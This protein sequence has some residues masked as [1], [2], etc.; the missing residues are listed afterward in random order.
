MCESAIQISTPYAYIQPIGSA[1]KRNPV[2]ELASSRT[3]IAVMRIGMYIKREHAD[4]YI[5][6]TD[7]H[8][9]SLCASVQLCQF[10][11]CRQVCT[12]PC[13]TRRDHASR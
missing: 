1:L 13:I 2:Y 9:L 7:I 12:G 10:C 8:Y 11:G 3:R 5:R 4:I 6:E